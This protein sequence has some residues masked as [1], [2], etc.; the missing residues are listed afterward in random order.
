MGMCYLLMDW[1]LASWTG[2]TGSLVRTQIWWSGK[3]S[4]TSSEGWCSGSLELVVPDQLRLVTTL[5]DE[6]GQSVWVS[7]VSLGKC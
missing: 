7:N 4:V 1:K 3:S 2:R 5:C 6:T